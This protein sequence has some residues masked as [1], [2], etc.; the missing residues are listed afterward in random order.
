MGSKDDESPINH[1]EWEVLDAF[2]RY[3]LPRTQVGRV[4]MGG[5][6]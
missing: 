5:Y 3:I 4:A 1:Y 6:E 2:E